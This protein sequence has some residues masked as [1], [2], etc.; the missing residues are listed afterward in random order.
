MD[1]P[2]PWLRYVSAGDLDDSVI[3][4]D[5]LDVENA[6]GESLGDVN[7]FI[8]DADS[9]QPYYVVV[10][11]KGWFKTK[12]YLLPVGHAQLDP[13]QKRLIADLSRDRIKKFPGFDLDKFEKWT[14]DDLVRFTSD[15]ADA[16]CVDVT[17]VT[18]EP[19]APWHAAPHY[20]MPGWWDSNYYRPDRAGAKG[21]VAGAQ[22]SPRETTQADRQ[23]A[24]AHDKSKG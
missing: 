16:C 18:T 20:Q 21:V 15:T 2:L 23:P 8:L 3:D 7:G 9:A 11:S 17:I 13:E 14:E 19:A 4:F 22:W 5:G 6:G 1:H 24:V 12:H 10:D